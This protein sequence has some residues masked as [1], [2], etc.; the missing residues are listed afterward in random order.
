MSSRTSLYR[1]F[2]ASGGLLYV[3]ISLNPVARLIQHS[4]GAH[5]FSDIVNISIEYFDTRGEA[6]VAER[7]AINSEKP[8]HNIALT[9]KAVKLRKQSLASKAWWE[10]FQSL[11]REP[12]G[13][14]LPNAGSKVG[15]LKAGFLPFFP[16]PAGLCFTGDEDG[17]R[18][19]MLVC[20]PGD[21]LHTLGYE[22]P[23]YE[24]MHLR[25][26]GINVVAH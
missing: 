22:M 21:T 20:E 12:V 1:H 25:R 8:K 5:W 24:W 18:R 19:A 14:V 2:D 23:T 4:S 13:P 3:G 10:L 7:I 15:Y 6:E 17:L 9:D 26:A 16:A 11:P